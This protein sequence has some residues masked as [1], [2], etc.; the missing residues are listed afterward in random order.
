LIRTLRK[1]YILCRHKSD[2][3]KETIENQF[4]VRVIKIT[5]DYLLIRSNHKRLSAII[6]ELESYGYEIVNVSG[7]LKGIYRKTSIT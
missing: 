7:T 3:D 5:H 6:S 2:I 4:R 1:R